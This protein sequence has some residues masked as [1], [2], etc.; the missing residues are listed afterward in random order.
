MS[1]HL[2][3]QSANVPLKQPYLSN[4]LAPLPLYG[5][6]LAFLLSLPSPPL[7]SQYSS[8]LLLRAP[9][10][11]DISTLKILHPSLQGLYV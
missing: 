2:A 6:G 9:L 7:P 11:G 1:P 3:D 5:N 10:L 4:M 8:N